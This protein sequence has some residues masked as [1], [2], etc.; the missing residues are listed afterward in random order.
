MVALYIIIGVIINIITV[1][2]FINIRNKRL[3]DEVGAAVYDGMIN[4]VEGVANEASDRVHRQ[5]NAVLSRNATKDKIERNYAIYEWEATV[6]TVDNRFAYKAPDTNE[7]WLLVLDAIGFSFSLS[8]C[9]NMP[10]LFF[11]MVSNITEVWPVIS[12]FVIVK[13]TGLSLK[14]AQLKANDMLAAI[15][16][17]IDGF[18]GDE[19]DTISQRYL[20][21]YDVKAF[22]NYIKLSGL[23]LDQK[24]DEKKFMAY[25]AMEEEVK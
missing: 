13:E 16:C 10:S 1:C 11:M 18:T 24:F 17:F 9:P 4:Y 5:I 2:I 12:R 21:A 25:Q 19:V 23:G 20:K 15:S 3:V 22:R 14:S 6:K 7:D 8:L